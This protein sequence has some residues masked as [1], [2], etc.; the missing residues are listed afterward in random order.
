MSVPRVPRPVGTVMTQLSGE[1]CVMAVSPKTYE[2][3]QKTD[4][5]G[6]PIWNIDIVYR[7][8]DGKAPQMVR[9]AYA[10]EEAPRISNDW[11]YD[12]TLAAEYLQ[13]EGRDGNP[14]CMWRYSLGDQLL[15]QWQ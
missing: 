14:V 9:A 6:V 13:F 2:G 4:R 15:G 7:P 12:A 3:E 1:S 8:R 11:I 5:D 10:G